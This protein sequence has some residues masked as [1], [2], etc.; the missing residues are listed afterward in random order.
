[1][2]QGEKQVGG[3]HYQFAMDAWDVVQAYGLGFFDG[4]ALKYV[5][6]ARH[7]GDRLTDLLKAQHYLE[8]E[9]RLA[10]GLAVR[11]EDMLVAEIKPPPHPRS[12]CRACGVLRDK[13]NA[14]Q[15]CPDKGGLV[16]HGPWI[17]P[18]EGEES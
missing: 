8:V 7:K 12:I 2:T 9:I 5:M 3:T 6:R 18:E 10:Q 4:N 1:M 16:V 17:R 13:E 15:F 11:P 14:L